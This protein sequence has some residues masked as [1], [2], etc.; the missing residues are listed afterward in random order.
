[1]TFGADEVNAEQERQ[2]GEYDAAL[3]AWLLRCGVPVGAAL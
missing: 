1:V 2:A 3:A